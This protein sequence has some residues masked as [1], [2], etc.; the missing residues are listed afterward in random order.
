MRKNAGAVV[1][2]FDAN[3]VTHIIT[4]LN[5]SRT[6]KMLGY[7]D[8]QEVPLSIP[9]LDYKWVTDTVNVFL[10]DVVQ[11]WSQFLTILA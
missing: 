6:A 7:K 11:S 10:F 5:A 3:V 2:T 1:P 4:D 9:T 8:I